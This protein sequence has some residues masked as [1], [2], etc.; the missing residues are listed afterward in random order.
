M[1]VR[2]RAAVRDEEIRAARIG[3]V[4]AGDGRDVGR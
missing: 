1:P 3:L 4:D 2:K